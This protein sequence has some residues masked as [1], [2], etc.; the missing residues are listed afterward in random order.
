M[1]GHYYEGVDINIREMKRD[2]DPA[3]PDNMPSAGQ[4]HTTVFDLSE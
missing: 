4:L 1:I 3:V 2:V